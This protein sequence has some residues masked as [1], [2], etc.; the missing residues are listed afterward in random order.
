MSERIEHP[1]YIYGHSRFERWIVQLT[2]QLPAYILLLWMA[3]IAYILARNFAKGM[4]DWKVAA[5]I[6]VLIGIGCF[7]ARLGLVDLPKP[8]E[9]Y[10]REGALYVKRGKEL[11]CVVGICD[12]YSVLMKTAFN[13]VPLLR[14]TCY[15]LKLDTSKGRRIVSFLS[16]GERHKFKLLV[17][18]YV[19]REA[20]G[21]RY[22][23]QN[24]AELN[25]W[26]AK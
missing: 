7:I 6:A 11:L 15:C 19:V 14:L 2:V 23:E 10:D 12:E 22:A 26:C 21:V 24:S 5:V 17:S 20:F 18:R 8:F 25:E 1:I 16:E 9:A 13:K 3:F 4:V